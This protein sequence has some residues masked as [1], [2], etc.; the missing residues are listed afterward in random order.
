M[1]KKE[2]K[3]FRYKGNFK[4]YKTLKERLFFKL[5]IFLKKTTKKKKSSKV[6][7]I[8]RKEL[9]YFLTEK[10]ETKGGKKTS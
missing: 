10:P 5:I 7:P 8:K 3:R 2:N 9:F 6:T 1:R 4:N